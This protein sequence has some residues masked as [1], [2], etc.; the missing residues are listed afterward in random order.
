MSTIRLTMAQALTRYMAAQMTEIDGE[1][2]DESV[3]EW[4]SPTGDPEDDDVLRP[5]V[6]LQDLV[7]DTE[8]GAGYL[9]RT[10]DLLAQDRCARGA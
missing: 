1:R 2:L 3:R 5:V 7:R 10:E 9:G 4:C 6:A 8:Q